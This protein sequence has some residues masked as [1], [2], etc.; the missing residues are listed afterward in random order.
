MNPSDPDDTVPDDTVPDDTV[1]DDT[2]PEDVIP[3]EPL[4]D[5]DDLGMPTLT[6]D[7]RQL[8]GAGD[9]VGGRTAER[10]DR[11]LRS[12]ST[13]SLALELLGIGWW[14][15]REILTDGHVSADGEPGDRDG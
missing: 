13:S 10:L 15:A 14:T 12:S 1:P 5:E 8:L 7:L 3:D 9:D 11:R 2:V 4:P 6:S